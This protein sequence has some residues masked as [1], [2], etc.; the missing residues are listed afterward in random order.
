MSE[1]VGLS[2]GSHRAPARVARRLAAC[3]ALGL[4]ALTL[5]C[6]DRQSPTAATRV[7]ASVTTTDTTTTAAPPTTTDPSS[8]PTTQSSTVFL[9]G[10]GDIA[11]SAFPAS[12]ENATRTA[13]L[14]ANLP[15]FTT[16]F[17]AGDNEQS[18]GSFGKFL[19]G[20]DKT[21]G[22]LP[23]RKLPTPGNHDFTPGYFQYFGPS[24]DLSGMGPTAGFYGVKLSESW[25]FIS[26]N[27]Q[28]AARSGSAQYA[29]LVQRLAE[30]A[31]CTI[32]VYHEPLQTNSENPPATQMRD[33]WNLLY[34]SGV[35][36]V[37]NGHNHVYE[38]F[39]KRDDS[40]RL[41][42]HNGVRQFTVGT[43]GYKSY[44]FP[45]SDYAY[46]VRHNDVHGVINFTLDAGR[47]SWEFLTTKGTLDSG[48]DTCHAPPQAPMRLP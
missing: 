37:V 17:T 48:S 4:L 6:G 21:W 26:L 12:I 19:S 20:F 11:D 9:A 41:N 47:Y 24:A 22:R 8:P 34:K 27:S 28:I 38:R 36:I 30:R 7:P 3:A 44:G 16:V 14:L 35:E 15:S 32:V 25:Q 23:N 31:P 39:G 5:A 13:A 40:L 2:R 46:E 18:D 33:V 43:G 10:A 29:W 45:R 42:P 1:S